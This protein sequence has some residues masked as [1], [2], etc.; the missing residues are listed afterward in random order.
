[1]PERPTRHGPVGRTDGPGEERGRIRDFENPQGSAKP[2]ILLILPDE[3][4]AMALGCYGNQQAQTPNIDRLSAD[5]VTFDYVCAPYPV[6]SPT[7]ASLMTGLF[8]HAN[9]EVDNGMTLDPSLPCV[10]ESL[11]DAGYKTAYIGKWHLGGYEG[12]I[13]TPQF[14]H[15]FED[16]W[17]ITSQNAYKPN[18]WVCQDGMEV[19]YVD[20][21]RPEYEKQRVVEFVQSNPSEPWFLLY[22]PLQP[23]LPYEMTDHYSQ[24]YDP[25]SIT[26]R[27]NVEDD[28]YRNEYSARIPFCLPF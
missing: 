18:T 28:N 7:R 9:G 13:I 12:G 24:M 17:I 23:H 2:N 27:P 16:P 1:M 21:W 25:A 19:K 5:G 15:G 22:S 14:R 6:C 26:L 20:E 4:R 3:L 10:G 8:P 11:R